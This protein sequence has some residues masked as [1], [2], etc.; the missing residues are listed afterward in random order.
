MPRDALRTPTIAVI[1]TGIS[2]MSAAWLLSGK[3]DVKV[4]EC[5]SRPG[6]HSNTAVLDEGG[7]T[8]PVDTGFIV[9]NENT[10]P[11]LTALFATL[12]VET[13]PTNMSFA[14][15]LRGGR[16]EYSGENL[17]GLVAQRRNLLRPRFWSMLYDLQRFY[18]NAPAVLGDV[19]ARSETLGG[20]LARNGYGAAFVED[21]LLPLS[22]AIWSSTPGAMLDYPVQSFVQF[23]DNHGLLNFVNRPVWRTVAGGSR[24]YVE[25]LTA[26]Y[27]DAIV[28]N[29]RIASIRRLPGSV[30]I[31]DQSG[32]RTQVDHV[33]FATHADQ[34]LA[35]LVNPT[36][37]ERALLSAFRYSSNRTYLHSDPALMPKRKAVWASWNFID[38]GGD[39]T[40]LVVSYW[41]NKLQ[42]LPTQ[43]DLFV[44]LNPHLPPAENAIHRVETYEHPLIDAAAIAAQQKLW[45]I[46]G[47]G[48]VWFCGAYFGAGFHED[49]L[50][51]GL[52]VAEEIGVLEG[53]ADV[54]RPWR[55]ENE[56]GRICISKDRR[57]PAMTG[58][59]S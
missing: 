36:D 26:P 2:G 20:Y 54:R 59:L 10:Y 51:S 8:V 56:S 29:A 41:M 58:A 50:Q 27:R 16:T 7:A 35:L 4:F 42:R 24:N 33:V 53:L 15:S 30:E 31:T 52:A 47:E 37:A 9:Y 12:G 57:V 40:P 43:R 32:N 55:V 45:S 14:A 13:E 48:G 6:G 46:Q 44:T 38:A 23:H 11:N 1:G 34:A 17:A 21:H 49:G 25:K 28:Y 5:A 18:R 3:C 22:A 19:R 39:D